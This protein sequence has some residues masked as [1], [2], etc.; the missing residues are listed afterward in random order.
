MGARGKVGS[1]IADTSEDQARS[2][3]DVSDHVRS[4]GCQVITRGADE[5]R[6]GHS[7]GSR[8][9]AWMGKLPESADNLF[10]G[11]GVQADAR[12]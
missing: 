4:T 12:V 3:D 11:H 2:G 5:D 9:G 8:V 6:N 7:R 10:S 1:G